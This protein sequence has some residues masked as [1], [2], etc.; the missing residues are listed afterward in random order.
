[1]KLMLFLLDFLFDFHHI[2]LIYY[3]NT[4]AL[5]YYINVVVNDFIE[6]TVDFSTE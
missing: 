5:I 1:M 3:V 2:R 4:I 6:F